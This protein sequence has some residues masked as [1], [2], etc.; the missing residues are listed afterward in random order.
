MRENVHF[1]LPSDMASISHDLGDRTLLVQTRESWGGIN[2]K[3]VV[4]GKA[5]VV[6]YFVSPLEQFY[7]HPYEMVRTNQPIQVK[8]PEIFLRNSTQW[9][10]PLSIS[11]MQT[12][13]WPF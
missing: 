10:D 8:N 11:W 7:L 3:I 9:K 1:F 13:F 5:S 2:D 6:A 4:L 12:S